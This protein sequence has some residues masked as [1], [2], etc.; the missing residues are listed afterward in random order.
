MAKLKAPLLS[1]G[2]S[3]KIAD[4]LVFFPWKGLNAVREYVI[5]SNPKTDPQNT[6]RGYVTAAVEDIHAKLAEAANPFDEVDKTA[7]QC[8]ANLHSTPRTWFNELVKQIVEQLRDALTGTI[9]TD[10]TAVP[11][12]GS[13]GVTIYDIDSVVTAGNWY[14]GTSPTSM[15]HSAAGAGFAGT[16]TGTLTP[17]VNGVKYYFQF[18]PS[19]PAGNIGDNS[20]IYYAV[21]AA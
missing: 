12:D 13:V 7:W 5:P 1:L 16:I 18:R 19:A 15:I 6:Q 21:P 4:T 2:A 20:G 9:L 17:L 3:G 14:W 8:R 10:C 11:A